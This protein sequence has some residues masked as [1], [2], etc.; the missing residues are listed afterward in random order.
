MDNNSWYEIHSQ[1]SHIFFCP[2][3]GDCDLKL[4]EGG[5][6][7]TKRAQNDK[8]IHQVVIVNVI[9]GS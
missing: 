7:D 5:L 9:E 8:S 1:I 3:I 6:A 2:A 4:A